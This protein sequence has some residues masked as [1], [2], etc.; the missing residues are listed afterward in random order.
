MPVRVRDRDERAEVHHRV[1]TGDGAEDG[2]RVDEVA[3]VDLDLAANVR[4]E[5]LESPEVVARVVADE[6]LDA[7]A[8]T[9]EMFDE[10]APDE[11][12]CPRDEHR[13]ERR[14]AR[15]GGGVRDHEVLAP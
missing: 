1:A 8:A 13:A 9:D 3:C 7:S 6:G 10:I 11:T 15:R 5:L 4:L 12:A 2:L 14:R